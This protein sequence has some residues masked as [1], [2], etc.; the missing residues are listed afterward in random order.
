MPRLA[1]NTKDDKRLAHGRRWFEYHCYEGEDSAD[2][3]L[4]HHTH[5]QVIVLRKI[6]D[7]IEEAEVGKMYRAKFSDGFEYDVCDDELVKSP[8]D[9][10]RPDYTPGTIIRLA[11]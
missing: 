7:S 1:F 2:A 5:Q 4:W 3:I 6:T 10:E 8:T 9:F 11:G